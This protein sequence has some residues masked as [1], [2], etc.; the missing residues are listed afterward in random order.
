MRYLLFVFHD[1]YPRG[2]WHDFAGAFD[3]LE[4]ARSMVPEEAEN[5]HIVDLES[6]VRVLS[7]PSQTHEDEVEARYAALS[8]PSQ[9]TQP[10]EKP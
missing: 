3:S 7:D 8:S 1:Y 2:G 6:G 5:W 4:T 10:K 9:I